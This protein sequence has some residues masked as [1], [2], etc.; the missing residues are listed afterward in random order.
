MRVLNSNAFIVLTNVKDKENNTGLY[1]SRGTI[2]ERIIE[3][4]RLSSAT[5]NRALKLLL[6]EDLIAEGVKKVNKKSYYVTSEGINKLK[7]MKGR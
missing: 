4:S 7:E 6:E 1:P 5:V 2:K 3:K